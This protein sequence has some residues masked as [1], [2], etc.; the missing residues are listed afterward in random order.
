MR[1]I[2]VQ[3]SDGEIIDLA[4]Q[5]HCESSSPCILDVT[6]NKGRIWKDSSFTPISLDIGQF[7]SLSLRGDFTALPF[8]SDSYDVLVF[9]PPHMPDDTGHNSGVMCS[10]WNDKYGL[11]TE[12]FSNS[13]QAFYSE[14]KRVLRPNGLVLTKI[15]DIVHNHKKMWSHVLMLEYAQA[16][17]FCACDMVIKVSNGNLKSSLWENVYHFKNAFSF[18]LIF[19]N[20]SSCERKHD[21]LMYN[22][23]QPSWSV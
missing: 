10:V 6:Y 3:T 12:G 19:R 2:N 4:I 8:S 15:A 18:W 14:A 23:Y 9:D 13:W 17:G 16:A 1:P 22:C 5:I 11:R 21:K 20:G 7:D